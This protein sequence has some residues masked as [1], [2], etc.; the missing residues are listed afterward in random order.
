MR[1]RVPQL[2]VLDL[3]QDYKQE[4]EEQAN[5]KRHGLEDLVLKGKPLCKFI[6]YSRFP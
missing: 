6:H 1:V 3:Q 5:L 4:V 2:R